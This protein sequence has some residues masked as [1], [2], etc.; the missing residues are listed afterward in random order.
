MPYIFQFNPTESLV[1]TRPKS[2]KIP[3]TKAKL[4]IFKLAYKEKII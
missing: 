3:E 2:P 4:V 1:K